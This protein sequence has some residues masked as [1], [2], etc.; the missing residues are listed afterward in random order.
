VAELRV[1]IV[2]EKP[3]RLVVF[4]L[5]DEVA[6]LLGDPLP[7]GIRGGGDVLLDPVRAG[8]SMRLC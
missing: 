1:P 5:D 4:E 8:N 2:D 3:E 7:V 6:C